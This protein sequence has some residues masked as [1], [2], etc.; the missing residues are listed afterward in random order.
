MMTKVRN[1]NDQ[2]QQFARF[3]Q[4]QL[5]FGNLFLMFACHFEGSCASENFSLFVQIPLTQT[6]F[7]F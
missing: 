2:W 5:F 7:G 1:K 6:R 4:G 3:E